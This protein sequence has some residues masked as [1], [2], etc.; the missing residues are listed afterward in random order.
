MAKTIGTFAAAVLSHQQSI[1][2]DCPHS[3]LN[4]LGWIN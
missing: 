1:Y 4:A 3:V 2:S